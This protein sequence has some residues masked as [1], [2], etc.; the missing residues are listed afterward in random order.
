MFSTLWTTGNWLPKIFFW[1]YSTPVEKSDFAIPNWINQKL[2]VAYLYHYPW[3]CPTSWGHNPI[4]EECCVN[5]RMSLSK[6]I[7]RKTYCYV[8]PVFLSLLLWSFK[9]R[10]IIGQHF[11]TNIWDCWWNHVVW[12]FKWNPFSSNNFKWPGILLN[13]LTEKTRTINIFSPFWYFSDLKG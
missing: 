10:D 11:P 13:R 4:S 5:H 2:T 12:P 1:H 7:N 8:I 3:L 6:S 9:L